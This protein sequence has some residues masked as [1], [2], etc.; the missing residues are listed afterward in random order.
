M[1]FGSKKSRLITPKGNLKTLAPRE[2]QCEARAGPD[3]ERE[4]SEN[5]PEI[6][7]SYRG[8]CEAP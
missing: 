3:D 2:V 8:L 7:K 1:A 4:R 6:P 5:E